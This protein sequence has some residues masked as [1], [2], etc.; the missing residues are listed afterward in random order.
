ML[1]VCS[2]GS[3]LW[4]PPCRGERGEGRMERGDEKGRGAEAA[5]GHLVE[6]SEGGRN[7]EGREEEERIEFL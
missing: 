6:G 4:R 7:G 5:G 3:T 1:P 2:I